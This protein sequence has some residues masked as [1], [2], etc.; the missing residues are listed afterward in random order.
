MIPFYD[1][2]T[3]H[4]LLS[5]QPYSARL[6]RRYDGPVGAD[7]EGHIGF[8]RVQDQDVLSAQWVLR[9]SLGHGAARGADEQDAEKQGSTEYFQRDLVEM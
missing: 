4:T 1:S 5:L 6:Q 8:Q 7:V 3:L 2:Q 9:L